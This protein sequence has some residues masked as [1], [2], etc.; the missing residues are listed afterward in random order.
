MTT[1]STNTLTTAAVQ[2]LLKLLRSQG[3]NL[4][5]L[6]SADFNLRGGRLVSPRMSIAKF[7]RVLEQASRGLN[8]PNIGLTL[9]KRLEL[10][11]FYLLSFLLSGCHSGREMLTLLR[12]Y[13]SLIISD[14]HAPD[15]FVGQQSIKLVFYVSEGSPF[16]TQARSELVASG[17][18][19]AGRAFGEN[20]YKI[21]GVGFR[22]AP[23]TYRKELDEFFG[24]PVQFNQPHNWISFTSKF[25]DK[26]LMQANPAFFGALQ[27]KA[28]QAMQSFGD[29]KEFSS[30]VMH[31]LYQ[32]PESVPITKEAVAELLNTS[33]RTLTR[34]LQEEDCQFSTLLRDVRLEKAKQALE[35]GYT[36][37][38]QL[39]VDLGF[40]DRRGFERAF[41]QW[42]G[43]TP[44]SYRKSFFEQQA[45]SHSIQSAQSAW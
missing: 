26:P 17:V 29:L 34:R 35:E 43:E 28:E 13:Y 32:W 31:V 19:N 3:L 4:D 44:A 38:Q 36:D 14:S 1:N 40:S 7:D 12:R 41:K 18:H 37:V 25:L 2:P 5:E 15:L 9:G 8:M 27:R 24:I 10:S 42:T 11:N 39:A 45:E 20:L 6:S 30:K 16:G 21:Q 23:P 22:N 33:S